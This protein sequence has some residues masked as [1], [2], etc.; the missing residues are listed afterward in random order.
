[1][2]NHQQR[3]TTDTWV[4]I[5]YTF[6]IHMCDVYGMYTEC[7]RDVYGMYTD[8]SGCAFFFSLHLY[9]LVKAH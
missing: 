1:M 5:L 9:Q 2:N 7:I 6:R 4:Y 3:T 8:V